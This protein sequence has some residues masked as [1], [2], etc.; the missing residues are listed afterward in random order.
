[1]NI[2]MKRC[3]S[4]IGKIRDLCSEARRSRDLRRCFFEMWNVND[5]HIEDCG[6]YIQASKKYSVSTDGFVIPFGDT[7][8]DEVYVGKRAYMN[9]LNNASEYTI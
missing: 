9:N 3:V 4:G 5:E 2:L 7:P 1:M 6:E 8:L